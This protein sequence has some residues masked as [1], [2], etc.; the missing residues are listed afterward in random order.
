M[1]LLANTASIL[2][3]ASGF[4]FLQYGLYVSQTLTVV[5]SAAQ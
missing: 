2:L 4:F 1:T 5:V 3:A